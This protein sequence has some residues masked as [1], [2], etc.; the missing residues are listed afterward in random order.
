MTNVI[1]DKSFD[2]AVQ[3]IKYTKFLREKNEYELSKQ[4]I[5]SGTSVTANIHE[6]QQAQS[7]KDFIHKLTIALKEAAETL[8]WLKLIKASEIDKSDTN[9]KLILQANDI[10]NILT[11]IIITTK[12]KLK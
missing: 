11:R 3:I 10:H 5:R 6:S 12:S 8:L 4:I 9:N 7:R 1:V 2:F